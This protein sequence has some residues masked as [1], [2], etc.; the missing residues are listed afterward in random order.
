MSGGAG[1]AARDWA[2]ARAVRRCEDGAVR[3]AVAPLLALTVALVLADSAVV[4]LALPDI[5]RN[6]DTTVGQVAWVLISFNLVLALVA[7]PT[8]VIFGAGPAA[9]HQR[10]RYRGLRRLLGGVRAGGV[11]RGADRGAVRAGARRR[12]GAGRM[13]GAPGRGVRRTARRDGLGHR[14]RR[15]HRH[16]PGRGRTADG[17]VLVAGH[18]RGAGAVCGAGG[19]GG[20]R[21]PGRTRAPAG[22]ASPGHPSQRDARPAVGGAHGGAVPAGPAAGRRLAPLPGDRGPDRVRRTGGGPRLSPA[23]APPADAGGGRGR[24]GVLPHRRGTGGPRDPAVGQ[25]RLDGRAPGA[26]GAGARA[27]RRPAQRPGD[28]DAA[29]ADRTTPAGPSAH[30]MSAWSWAW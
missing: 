17:G 22:P 12:V 27:D 19:A 1:H 4:T 11:D 15:R 18:L 30:V 20:A 29:A 8:A 10:R 6:L 23:R 24:G 2:R 14:R 13:P 9:D 25:P 16:G 26:G 3:R 28:G 21:R 5:L 7:V